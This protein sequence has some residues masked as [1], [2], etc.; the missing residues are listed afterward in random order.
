M[1][2]LQRLRVLAI[3]DNAMSR[4]GAG[5]NAEVPGTHFTEHGVES[6]MTLLKTRSQKPD[7]PGGSFAVRMLEILTRKDEGDTDVHGASLAQ[8]QRFSTRAASIRD[9]LKA[10]RG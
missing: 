9:K 4:K 5:K 7:G 2:N 6:F 1:D 8:L 3:V 10:A